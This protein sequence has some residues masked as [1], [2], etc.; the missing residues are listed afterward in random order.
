MLEQ[1]Y[2]LSTTQFPVIDHN[3]PP[4]ELVDVAVVGAGFTG[5]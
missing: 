3:A 1:N 5:L 4:P 2:W